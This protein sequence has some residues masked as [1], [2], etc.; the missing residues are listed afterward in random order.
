MSARL[1]PERKSVPQTERCSPKGLGTIGAELVYVTAPH[2]A[3][4]PDQEIDAMTEAERLKLHGEM[5]PEDILKGWW[6]SNADKTGQIGYKE[7][8]HFLK[9]VWIEKGPFDG[10]LGSHKARNGPAPPLRTRLRLKSKRLD[11]IHPPR[12][13]ILYPGSSRPQ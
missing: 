13:L 11:P 5:K 8:I 2:D 12:F 10:I 1:L 9:K 4:T 7:S 6:V 3:P